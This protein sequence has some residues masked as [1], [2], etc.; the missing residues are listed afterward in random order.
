MPY[1]TNARQVLAPEAR[2]SENL[3]GE[4]AVLLTGF[5]PGSRVAGYLPRS[6]GGGLR[7]RGQDPG[8][9]I[10]PRKDNHLMRINVQPDDRANFA[11]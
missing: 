8:R 1:E 10:F 7:R 11:R 6:P 4:A 2:V 9:I 5:T 3:P